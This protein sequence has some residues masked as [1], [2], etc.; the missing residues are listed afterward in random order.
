MEWLALSSEISRA[1]T[2]YRGLMLSFRY[3]S[4]NDT[5]SSG[6]NG[7]TLQGSATLSPSS[8]TYAGKSFGEMKQKEII[9]KH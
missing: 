7:V 9:K 1:S 5:L 3:Q 2:V 8:A 4:I 6:V